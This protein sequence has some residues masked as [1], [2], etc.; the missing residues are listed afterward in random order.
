MKLN[1]VQIKKA[2]TIGVAILILLN[3]YTFI[4]ALPETR[5]LDPGINTSGTILAKDFSAYYIGAWRLW[6]NPAHVYT[7]GPL[8]D[9]EPFVYPYPETYKYLP[10]FLLLVTPFLALSYRNAILAFDI[11]QFSLLPLMAYMIYKLL[12][13]KHL[14]ITFAV[15]I[16]ALLLP[17]P[18]LQ[19]GL[20]ASYYWQWGEGQAKIFLT[21]L[22]ILS[23][24]L[25]KMRRPYLS[26][27]TLAFGFFDARFGLL[28]LALFI[29]YNRQNLKPA[30]IGLI[31]TLVL[32]NA[33]LLYPGMGLSFVGMAFASAITTGLYYYSLI[34][35]LTLMALIV[36]NFK[37]LV[38]AFD[39][40]GVFV[41]YTGA[42]KPIKTE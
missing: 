31:G 25:G 16:I 21:F 37:G 35:F 6:H 29:M 15:M 42:Q 39:W 9:G 41:N 26:G 30:T 17:F 22:I 2:F 32:S 5:A 23:F 13:K 36:V 12:D 19:W 4:I 8:A 1:P 34:P 14:A 20:S 33:M 10:S 27:A 24:Y 18:T 11:V 38:A 40:R 28:A 7:F 3:L